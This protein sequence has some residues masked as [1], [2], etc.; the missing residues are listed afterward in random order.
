MPWSTESKALTK[1]RKRTSVWIF[2]SSSFPI[3]CR[4]PKS[5]VTHERPQRN[6]CCALLIPSRTCSYSRVQTQRYD[7]RRSSFE[8]KPPDNWHAFSSQSNSACHQT[9]NTSTAKCCNCGKSW[10]HVNAP[11]PARGKQCKNCNRP[12]HFA[13]VCRSTRRQSSPRRHARKHVRN[14]DYR[15]SPSTSSSESNDL[16]Y[17]VQNEQ[18][19]PT[20]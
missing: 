11:C 15:R 9:E 17:S 13:K 16:L 14:I 7:R 19:K 2:W 4:V 12:G 3:W 8:T 20:E 5:C 1:S 10:P 18:S 6:P